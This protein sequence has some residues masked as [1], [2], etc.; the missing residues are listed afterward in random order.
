MN[1]EDSGSNLTSAVEVWWIILKL[2]HPNLLQEIVAMEEG[3]KGVGSGIC[4][5]E[6]WEEK[7]GTKLNSS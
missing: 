5:S 1:K 4:C 3:R 7:W 2:S 6:L